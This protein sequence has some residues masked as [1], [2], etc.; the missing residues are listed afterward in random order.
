MGIF[1]FATSSKLVKW[2]NYTS[3]LFSWCF[4]FILKMFSKRMTLK[5]WYQINYL[6]LFLSFHR[7]KFGAPLSTAL[8]NGY[9]PIPM[10]VSSVL[11]IWVIPFVPHSDASAADNFR[12]QCDKRRNCSKRAISPFATNVFNFLGHLCTKCKVSY[13]DHILSGVRPSFVVCRQHLPK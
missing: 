3:Y 5:M 4:L 12:K 11:I 13:C 7:V 10:V 9:L 2:C 1:R 6:F 8:K